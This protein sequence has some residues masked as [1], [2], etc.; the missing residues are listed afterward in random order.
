M[1]VASDPTILDSLLCVC[2]APTNT[3]LLAD[4]GLA[5][6]ADETGLPLAMDLTF[7]KTRHNK[8]ISVVYNKLCEFTE[9][10]AGQRLHLVVYLGF[11]FYFGMGASVEDLNM[12][13][14]GINKAW[15]A[16]DRKKVP[17]DMTWWT[18]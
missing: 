3:T 17:L 9:A 1:L 6:S 7:V 18:M 15:L 14:L 2:A 12:V 13:L 10:F 4:F 11:L 16:L 5:W 8:K